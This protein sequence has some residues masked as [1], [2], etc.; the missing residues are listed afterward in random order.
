VVIGPSNPVISIGPILAIP[1]I[2]H[3]LKEAKAPAVAV[4]PIVDGEVLKG[5][6]ADFMRWAGVTLDSDGVA[7]RYAGL[8]DGLVA[9]QPTDALPTLT[10]NTLMDT[11]ATR[12]EVARQAL[13]FALTLRSNG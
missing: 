12:R 10:A 5:P 7:T 4:S 11:P 6:T 1:E 13:E 9:D 2:R 3:T 8:I